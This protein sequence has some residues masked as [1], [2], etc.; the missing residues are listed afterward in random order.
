MCRALDRAV[1]I[2][3]LNKTKAK[4]KHHFEAGR[5]G[6]GNPVPARQDPGL[7]GGSQT[8]VPSCGV[9][10]GT[11]IP[12]PAQ[13]WGPGQ[14][15]HP[16]ACQTPPNQY[17]K[18][19]APAPSP[20]LLPLSLHKPVPGSAA[21]RAPFTFPAATNPLASTASI[22]PQETSADAAGSCSCSEL[23]FPLDAGSCW[24]FSLE[25]WDERVGAGGPQLCASQP[26]LPALRAGGEAEEGGWEQRSCF[27]QVKAP[28]RCKDAP[29]RAQS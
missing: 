14:D 24:H 16:A 1:C 19:G 6:Q 3:P 28:V 26:L 8:S 22:A 11:C 10:G 18:V 23:I 13:C 9:L 27:S 21:Q 12:A 15:T 20:T 17:K 29:W 7:L 4:G 2:K 25:A 5:W